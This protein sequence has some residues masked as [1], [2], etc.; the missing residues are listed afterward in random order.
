MGGMESCLLGY[1]SM[2]S[3]KGTLDICLLGT[4][5]SACDFF[6]GDPP[7]GILHVLP[8]AEISLMKAGILQ[9][10]SSCQAVTSL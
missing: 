9:H 2:L 10:V 3:R 6:A 5:L 7:D 4:P 8:P 1:L